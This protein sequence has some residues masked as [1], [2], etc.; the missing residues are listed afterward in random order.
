MNC[1]QCQTPNEADARFCKSCGAALTPGQAKSGRRLLLWAALIGG[2]LLAA[3]IVALALFWWMQPPPPEPSDGFAIDPTT[4]GTLNLGHGAELTLPP[5]GLSGAVQLKV[6]TASADQLGAGSPADQAGLAAAV[7]QLPPYLSV[8]S[9]LYYFEIKGPPPSAALL[10]LF[11]PTTAEARDLDLYA[12][13]GTAWHWLPS[14]LEVDSGR[15]TAQLERLPP[16]VAL[17]R[18]E[19]APLLIAANLAPEA[20]LPAEAEGKL[21]ELLLTGF[22]LREDGSFETDPAS[23]EVKSTA[24]LSL[25]PSLRNWRDDGALTA[26]IGDILADPARRQRHLEAIVGLALAGGYPAVQL[27]YRASPAQRDT[28]SAFITDLAAAL[29]A[30]NRSLLVRVTAPIQV[31]ATRWDT[32]AYDWA[33]IGQV[34]DRLQVPLPTDP[35]TVAQDQIEALLTWA[36]GQVERSKLQPVVSWHHVNMSEGGAVPVS[37]AEALAQLGPIQ[38][39]PESDEFRPGNQATLSLAGLNSGV[40]KVDPASRLLHFD[41]R[42]QAGKPYQ[43]YL[44]TDASRSQGLQRLT[45]SA[46]SLAG[47]VIEGLLDETLTNQT[48]GLLRAYQARDMVEVES[49]PV[50]VWTIS[51]ADTPAERLSKT[52]PLEKTDYTWVAPDKVGAYQIEVAL[53]TDKGSSAIPIAAMNLSVEAVPATETPTP[54]PTPTLT[55]VSEQKDTLALVAPTAKPSPSVTPTPTSTPTPTPTA[56]PT[57]PAPPPPPRRAYQLAYTVWDGSFHNLYIADTKSKTTQLIF[58]RAAGPSWSPDKKRLFFV[59]QQGVTQQIRENR[60]ACEFGT[61]SDGVVAVDLPS[62]LRDI[63]QVQDGPWFCDRKGVDLQSEPSD[64]CTANGI[65][66][67]QNLDW[68]VGS[69]RWASTAPTGDAVAYDAKPGEAYRI[70]FRAMLGTS[71]QFRFE[72]PGEQGSWAPDGQRMVYRSGRDNKQGLWISNRD[73]SNATRISEDGTDSFP[74]WSPNGRTIAFSRTANEN[75]DIY[76]VNVD[77]SNL[78]RLTDVPGHDTLPVYTPDG[79]IIFRSDRTGTWGIWRMSGNGRGQEEIIPDAGV[80]PDWSYSRMDVK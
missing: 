63:C 2:G 26:S 31:A 71:Q 22:S 19:P 38:T 69:A 13:D 21:N 65:S 41:G 44:H 12:W 54:T 14:R 51:A 66:V 20:P 68:K 47:V 70:Y 55:P 78:Q 52:H 80:G 24:N 29:H 8:Q 4:G 25:I 74:A 18:R 1:P 17:L 72:I 5:E 7:A 49:Q 76:T 40:L 34:A 39:A 60:V 15:F 43:F 50:W 27:D 42:D 61:I 62:P 75:T 45:A 57:A 30:Q 56:T 23:S 59:G 53:S 10:S 46:Y 6:G 58:T 36:I 3:I 64:V 79:E 67:Y 16:T 37:M 11:S 28:L 35:T 77:G 48:W 73:D 32:G 9:P 33:A